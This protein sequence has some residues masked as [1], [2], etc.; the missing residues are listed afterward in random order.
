MTLCLSSAA[1]V[2]LIPSGSGINAMKKEVKSA[3]HLNKAP[4]AS[5]GRRRSPHGAEVPASYG[6]VVGC[7]ELA[8]V[9]VGAPLAGGE[10]QLT[11]TLKGGGAGD[12]RRDGGAFVSRDKN[13]IC[14]CVTG[15]AGAAH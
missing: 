15:R 10:L 13:F 3:R 7:G 11:F 6:R 2:G 9:V 12:L 14:M 1:A 4:K 5:L 8:A